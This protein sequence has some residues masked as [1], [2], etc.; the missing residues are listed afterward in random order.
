MCSLDIGIHVHV[1]LYHGILVWSFGHCM[2]FMLDVHVATYYSI[3]IC[4]YHTDA[5]ICAQMTSRSS[6]N[7]IL[8]L[9]NDVML[10]ILFL[11]PLTPPR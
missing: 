1:L 7:V 9:D 8:V 10:I 5:H 2:N 6:L 4:S 11:I 3:W